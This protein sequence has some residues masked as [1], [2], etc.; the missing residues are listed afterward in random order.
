M[1]RAILVLA[2]STI[3]THQPLLRQLSWMD[4]FDIVSLYQQVLIVT[5]NAALLAAKFICCM[6]AVSHILLCLLVIYHFQSFMR[7]GTGA[8]VL[9]S[10]KDAEFVNNRLL[11][12]GVRNIQHMALNADSDMLDTTRV[13]Q[14]LRRV[15]GSRRAIVVL[16][17]HL[18]R[19]LR[20]M[21]DNN[22]LRAATTER[23]IP[24]GSFCFGILESLR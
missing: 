19:D 17:Q 1:N 23:D 24:N 6:L 11:R 14:M 10:S 9:Y 20:T 8:F 5:L 13:E 12:R 18:I 3:S 16:T 15:K 22:K 21:L 7:R 4:Q 2:I